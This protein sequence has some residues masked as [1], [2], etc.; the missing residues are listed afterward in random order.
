[1]TAAIEFTARKNQ[2]LLEWIKGA[3]AIGGVR[4]NVRDIVNAVG[5]SCL[6]AHFADRARSIR[7]FGTDYRRY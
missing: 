4:A 1:M 6:A 5:S 2:P 7:L 3:K